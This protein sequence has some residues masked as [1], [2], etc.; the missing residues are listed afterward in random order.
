MRV[1]TRNGDDGVTT[2]YDGNDYDKD[3]LSIEIVGVLDEFLASIDEAIVSLENQEKT[4]LLDDIQ[5]L[6]WQ[7]AGEI[8][9]GDQ[10]K[11]VEDAI[12]ADDIDGLEEQIDEYNPEISHFVRYRTENGVRLN[13]ARVEC[14]RLERRLTPAMRDDDIRPVIYK[15]INRLSD[16]LYVLACSEERRLRPQSD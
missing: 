15:Y 4:D 2:G 13:R 10:G 6:L 1:Y 16:L 7:T 12:Q 8:S 5:D 3:A 14:R 11:N 9:L